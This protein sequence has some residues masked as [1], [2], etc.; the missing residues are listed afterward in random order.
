MRTSVRRVVFGCLGCIGM[1]G[2]LLAIPKPAES[3]SR[4][5]L[6]LMLQKM[7]KKQT[8]L[9][10]RIAGLTSKLS[11]LRKEGKL[12]AWE[13]ALLKREL[14]NADNVVEKAKA[15]GCGGAGRCRRCKSQP[16]KQV[17]ALRCGRGGHCRKGKALSKELAQKK[18]PV[19]SLTGPTWGPA[20]AKVTIA[21]FSDFQCPF[22]AR[23]ASIMRKVKQAFGDKVRIVFKHLPLAFHKQ[24]YIAA[25]ASMEA[26]RQG[27][28]WPFHDKIF[29]NNRSVNKAQLLKWAGELKMDVKAMKHALDTKKYKAVVDADLALAKK[30]HVRGTPTFF[31]NGERVTGAHPFEV[32]AAKINKHLG[33]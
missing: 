15:P 28:F 23:G 21:A 30:W 33:Q 16:K 25:Q 1:L 29:A 20:S 24:A 9:A 13:L 12:M 22:C 27:K 3:H 6:T 32:F 10:Q 5:E 26:Q 7:K 4:Q 19:K 18:M 8:Q 17:K 14:R 2:L 31:V 11:S